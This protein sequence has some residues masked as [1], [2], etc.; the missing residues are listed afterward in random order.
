MTTIEVCPHCDSSSIRWKNARSQFSFG[1]DK[2]YTCID[3]GATFEGP[4][5]RER[6]GDGARQGLAKRLMDANPDDVGR[7]AAR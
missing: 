1:D 4:S 2:P 7:E 6:R 5:E 3:C